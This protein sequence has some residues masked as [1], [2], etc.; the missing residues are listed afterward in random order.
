M[1]NFLIG[2]FYAFIAQIGTFIQ[3]QCSLKYGWFQK[4]PLLV[5]MFGVP[6]GWLYFKSV[7]CFMNAYNGELWAGRLI[8]FG[9]GIT[10][11]TLMSYIL[12]KEPL[13]IKSLVCVFLGFLIIL[14]QVFWK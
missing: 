6:L 8:G 1:N 14:I 3:L 2:S 9:I 5:L 10:T 11:F 13:T 12:F 4:Y 7:E